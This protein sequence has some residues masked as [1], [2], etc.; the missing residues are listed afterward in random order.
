MPEMLILLVRM[1]LPMLRPLELSVNNVKILLT[2]NLGT[3]W[4]WNLYRRVHPFGAAFMSGIC[5][6]GKNTRLG[7]IIY[8]NVSSLHINWLIILSMFRWVTVT[9]SFWK[10][11]SIRV[12]IELNT[13]QRNQAVLCEQLEDCWHRTGV[14]KPTDLIGSRMGTIEL[15]QCDCCMIGQRR[16]AACEA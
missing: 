9:S 6:T 5:H 12:N 13:H 1:Q 7:N 4:R 2:S 11:Y 8:V 10:I 15:I 14:H 3:L 16:L